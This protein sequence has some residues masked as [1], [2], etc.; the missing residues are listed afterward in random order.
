MVLIEP[1][2]A[3]WP[4]IRQTWNRNIDCPPMATYRGFMGS[5]TNDEHPCFTPWP[6][7]T[8]APL[9][10]SISYKYLWESAD[11]CPQMTLDDFIAQ[12]RCVPDAINIDVE[13]AELAVLRGAENT[14]KFTKRP[15]VWVSLHPDLMRKWYNTTEDQVHEFMA[16]CGYTGTHLA[17]DHEE[18]WLFHP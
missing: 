12:S 10:V 2:E 5:E 13:G 9:V 18:H 3:P 7:E 15:L 4:N 8:D 6:A 1:S 17:T 16:S 11:D 14:F